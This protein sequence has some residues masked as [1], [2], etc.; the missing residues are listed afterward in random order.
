MTHYSVQTRDIDYTVW[1]FSFA[2]NMTKNIGKN[3][4]SQYSQKNL[5]MLN[6]LQR[7]DLKLLQTQQ[8]QT[9]LKQLGIWLAIKPL[10]KLEKY[11]KFRNK[12]IQRKLKISIR[13]KYL[14]K[15]TYL[16]NKNRNY[17]FSKIYIIL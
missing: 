8:L 2:K 11:Q 13:K 15:D 17:W 1:I 3:L 12:V 6:N 7:M 5:V 10:I 14:E 9:Q 16:Q 4:S